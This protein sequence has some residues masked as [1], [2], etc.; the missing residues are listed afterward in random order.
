MK[1]VAEYLYYHEDQDYQY[2]KLM[3]CTYYRQKQHL[4]VRYY[5]H[6]DIESRL[7]VL[8]K[9]L[10]E[11]FMQQVN[12]PLKYEFIYKK[13]YV[14]AMTLQIEIVSFLCHKFGDLARQTTD[15]DVKVIF[16]NNV[17]QINLYL[18]AALLEFLTNSQQ[19][20][21]FQQSLRAKN[22]HEIIFYENVKN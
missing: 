17:W 21:S 3:N 16:D 18:P 7:P 5:Y 14:D 8:K 6:Q 11:L 13:I 9:R 22:F 4:L 10:E 12:L 20:Q 1:D 2:L 15:E 19:W